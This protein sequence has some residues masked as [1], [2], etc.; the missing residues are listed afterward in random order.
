MAFFIMKKIQKVVIIIAVLMAPIFVFLFL[1]QFG[2]NEFELPIL[3]SEGNPIAD[4]STDSGEYKINLE[5]LEKYNIKLPGLFY[6]PATERDKYYSDL[7]N[8]LAK[9]QN[10]TIYELIAADSLDSNAGSASLHFSTS[11]YL[12]FINCTLILGEDQRLNKA[13][14][15]KFVLVDDVRQIRGY[16]NCS[17]LEDIERLDVELDILLN[18]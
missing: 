6:V 14:L 1:K 2:A 9:Y 13:I 4:C 12:D 17:D 16:Y 3:Y 7:N 8:V 18:Y 10:V 11:E 15:N 5:V